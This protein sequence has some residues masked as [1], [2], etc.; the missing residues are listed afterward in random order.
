MIFF[1]KL[2]KWFENSEGQAMNQN[3]KCIMENLF[4]VNISRSCLHF[5]GY[6]SE[7]RDRDHE[8]I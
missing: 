6:L 8:N 4:Y 5:L 3:W 2:I 1:K 7:D